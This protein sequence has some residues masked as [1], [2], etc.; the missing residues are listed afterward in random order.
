MDMVCSMLSNSTLPLSL[1]MDALKTATHIINRVP[2]KSVPKSPYKLWT[3]RKPSTNYFHVWGCPAEAKIFSP[4]IGKLDPKTISCHFIGYP[5][6]SK[7][8]HFSYPNCT[9][10]FM[11]TRHT[12]FLE[13]DVSS[14][15]WEIDL[16]EIRDYVPP[17]MTHDYIPT[18]VVAPHVEN[19]PSSENTGATPTITENE[20]VLMVDEQQAENSGANELPLDNEQEVEPEQPQDEI[21]ESLPMRRSQHERKSAIS[22]DYVVY[23]S[24][25]V[26][27]MDDP[28]SYKRGHD[29]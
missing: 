6:K 5:D 8:C 20:D 27:K 1:W 15:P 14:T 18:I 3:G 25:D 24:E 16:E 22:K 17:P 19:V 2:S 29:E 21:S 26:G 11:D 10:K 7:G 13:C 23:I 9:T 28:T 4:E 12:V